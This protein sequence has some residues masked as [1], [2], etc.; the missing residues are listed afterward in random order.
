MLD[1][2]FLL[3]DRAQHIAGPGDMR[4]VNLGL[5]FV[6]VARGA[7]RLPSSRGCIGASTQ[8]LAD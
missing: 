7:R 6:F 5:E 4:K 2:F 3:R 8:M 1:R